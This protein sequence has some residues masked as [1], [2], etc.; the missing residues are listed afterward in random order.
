MSDRSRLETA[1]LVL[2]RWTP[3]DLAPFAAMNA[4]PEVMRYFPAPL[5]RTASDALAARADAGFEERGYG[6]WALSLRSDGSFL[7][8]T[9][10]NPMP[11]GVP[12]SDGVEVGWRL[13]RPY[14]G[15]GYATE[16]ARAAIADGFE[17]VGLTRIDSIT[18]VLNEPSQRVMRR[19]GMS[20]AERFEHPR[21]PEGSPLR[22]HIR[23]VL[24]RPDGMD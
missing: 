16:A 17:A 9:G 14:W 24:E 3:D 4:D 15:H 22:P 8:F 23:Y 10:L 13:A 7:G 5:S 18:A 21:V 20:P 11:P 6:L 2:R 1:R 19:L 12:G